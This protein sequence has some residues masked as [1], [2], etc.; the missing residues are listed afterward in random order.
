MNYCKCGCGAQVKNKFVVGHQIRLK[1][2]MSDPKIRAKI[3]GDNAPSKRLEVR[4]KIGKSSKERWKNPKYRENILKSLSKIAEKRKG[5]PR[6][7]EVKR[8][9]SENKERAKKISIAKT[10]VPRPDMIENK[11]PAKKPGVG[12]KI[13]IGI[14]KAFAEGRFDTSLEK[15]GMWN[16]GISFEP[17]GIEFNNRL[18]ET[19]RRRD[20]YQCKLCG[21]FQDKFDRA[22]Q[23]HHI[24]CNKR[25]N[26]QQNLISLCNPC[27][28]PTRFN[29]EEW[30]SFFQ[31]L[32]D[33]EV[34]KNRNE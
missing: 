17:Y 15:N 28:S 7:K 18:K 34:I 25:N 21:I 6:T 20:N 27:H 12:K 24:D 3:S 1:N 19:I 9:I 32:M 4:K 16:G 13:S 23:V 22:L 2:P 29:R 10:G 11:N 31:N 5:I 26:N 14:K 30:S 8:K 33:K